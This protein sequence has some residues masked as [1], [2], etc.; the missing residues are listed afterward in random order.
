MQQRIF[1]FVTVPG[2]TQ[3]RSLDRTF[4]GTLLLVEPERPEL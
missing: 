1:R 3:T 2:W 4:M